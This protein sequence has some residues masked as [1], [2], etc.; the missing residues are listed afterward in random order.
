MVEDPQRAARMGEEGRAW[1]SETFSQ[2]A[3][4]N[5][6][7]ELLRPYGYRNESGQ[8]LAHAEGRV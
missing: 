8:R 3:L 6:L 2:D 5:C 1:A 7:R 4:S